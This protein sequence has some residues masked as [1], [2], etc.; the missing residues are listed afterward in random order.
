VREKTILIVED[1]AAIRESLRDAFE[2]HGYRVRCAANGL[3]GLEALRRFERPCAVILDL[4]MP[5]MTGHELYDAMQTDPGLADIPVIV[6][7]A[8]PSGAPSGALL[9]KKPINLLAML[10]TIQK[11]CQSSQTS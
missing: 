4:M 7:S 10:T 2:D 5:V 9:L 11:F 8:D 3:E 1:D 6:S